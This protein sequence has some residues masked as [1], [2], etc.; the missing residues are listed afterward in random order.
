ME[1]VI[2]EHVAGAE[3]VHI[4]KDRQVQNGKELAGANYGADA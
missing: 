4:M 3:L 1:L 2:H